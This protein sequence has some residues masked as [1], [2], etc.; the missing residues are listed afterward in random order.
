MIRSWIIASFFSLTVV[1]SGRPP[2]ATDSIPMPPLSEL[3][4]LH[5]ESAL[6]AR[7]AKV[8]AIAL[9]TAAL[10]E[11]DAR[12]VV[13]DVELETGLR[14]DDPVRFGA[15]RIVDAVVETRT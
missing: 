10:E 4:R 14:A 9:N 6:I 15:A 5:E 8:A 12:A 3:V 13:T 2:T 7:P 11:N 1:W